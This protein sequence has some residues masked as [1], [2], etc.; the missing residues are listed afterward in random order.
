MMF[1]NRISSSTSCSLCLPETSPPSFSRDVLRH[2]FKVATLPLELISD[3]GSRPGHPLR[4]RSRGSGFEEPQGAVSRLAGTP[5][6]E[7]PFLQS[8]PQ[9]LLPPPRRDRNQSSK[10][11]RSAKQSRNR[12]I[13][14]RHAHLARVY[15][16]TSRDFMHDEMFFGNDRLDFVEA[17][18]RQ[19]A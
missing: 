18:I 3:A 5:R 12:R 17:A 15:A 14:R 10:R 4:L 7:M 13:Q 19:A 8:I 6:P 16:G 2:V 11:L 1:A 9:T